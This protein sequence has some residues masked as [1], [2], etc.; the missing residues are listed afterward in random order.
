MDATGKQAAFANNGSAILVSWGKLSTCEYFIQIAEQFTPCIGAAMA[1]MVANI[2]NKTKI[3]L[4]K[5]E[6]AGHSVGAHAVGFAGC[7]LNGKVGLIIGKLNLISS[8]IYTILRDLI[9]SSN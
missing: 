6:M 8:Y 2:S 3:S 1:K 7:Y 5:F 9:F 4:D